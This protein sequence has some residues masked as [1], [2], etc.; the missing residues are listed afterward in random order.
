[1]KIRRPPEVL[2]TYILHDRVFCAR[3]IARKPKNIIDMNL[4]KM[5]PNWLQ[6]RNYGWYWCISRGRGYHACEQSS[7]KIQSIDEQVVREVRR[8]I[9]PDGFRE[10][11][12]ATIRGKLE[13]A[14]KKG[15]K[16]SFNM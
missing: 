8:L 13:N 6:D 16:C 3:C 10:R 11:V 2:R 15:A 4:G 1:M 14:K 9:I 12:E 7:V 5:R